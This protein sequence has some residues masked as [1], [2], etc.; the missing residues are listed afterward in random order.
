MSF[1]AV[2]TKKHEEQAAKIRAADEEVRSMKRRV[3]F[4]EEEIARKEAVIARLT[5][6]LVPGRFSR[7]L[8]E[9]IRAIARAARVD[10]AQ[11]DVLALADLVRERIEDGTVPREGSVPANAVREDLSEILR[12]AGGVP[13][14]DA[15]VGDVVES[16]RLAVRSLA[17]AARKMRTDIA[18]ERETRRVLVERIHELDAIAEMNTGKGV[19]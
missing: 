10:G 19:A 8:V 3:L 18:V 15:T 4:L 2:L 7:D 12:D 16:L 6:S 14:A 17:E 11:L 5:E 1:E 13:E 9:K